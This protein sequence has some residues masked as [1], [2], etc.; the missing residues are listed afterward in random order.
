MSLE[1]GVVKKFEKNAWDVAN[2]KYISQ[3]LKTIPRYLVEFICFSLIVFICLWLYVKGG[4]SHA[5]PTI[6]LFAVSLG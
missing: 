6:S 5:I 4:L 1:Q 2:S 3:T